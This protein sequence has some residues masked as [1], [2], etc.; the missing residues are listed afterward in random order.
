MN[1]RARQHAEPG[2]ARPRCGLPAGFFRLRYFHGKQMR[3]ADY[4][5]E[6]RYHMGKMRFHNQRLHGAGILCGLEVCVLEGLWLRVARGAA[7]DDCGREIVVGWDQCV[8]VGA[9]FKQQKRVVR[10]TGHDPCKPDENQR[11]HVCV[12]LCYAECAGGPEPAPKAHC[13]TPASCD[14]G[15]GGSGGCAPCPDPC[16]ESAEY[17]RVTEEFELRLMF[18]DEAKRVSAH[19]LFPAAGDIEDA[20][21]RAFGGIG[22]LKSVAQPMRRGCPDGDEGWLLLA[23]FDLVIDADDPERVREIVDIDYG[24]ASQVLLSTEVIQY[25]LARLAED[26]DLNI[27]GPEIAAIRFRKLRGERYQFLLELTG[28]IDDDSLDVDSSFDLRQLTD[29]GWT[30]P[31]SNAIS[32]VYKPERVDPS[33]RDGP[34]IYI[35]VDNTRGH[36]LVTGGRYQLFTPAEALPVVDEELRPLRPRRLMW[37]FRIETGEDGDLVMTPLGARGSSHG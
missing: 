36:F 33:D 32:M 6:Q 30:A 19:G 15:T 17:G 11:V 21:A 37:R 7:I 12:V 16:A 4:V 18:A 25:L 24:C 35:D 1:D 5:D 3:L 9:W 31:A 27:G 20:V 34:T 14:Y 28:P 23:C 13:V 29:T 2:C 26:A 22:L 8:D 10:D